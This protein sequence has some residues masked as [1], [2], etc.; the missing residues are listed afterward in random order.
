MGFL[1]SVVGILGFG[2]GL[3]IGIVI[4]FYFFIYSQPDDVE[5][6]IADKIYSCIEL[7]KYKSPMRMRRKKGQG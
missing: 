5:L 1:S 2:I 4:G 3:P 6:H 7:N